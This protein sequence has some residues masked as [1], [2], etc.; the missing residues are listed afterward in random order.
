M[1]SLHIVT[2]ATQS[3]Y[4]YPYLVDTIKKNNGNIKVL[5]YGEKWQGFSWR[6]DLMIN[7]LSELDP[8]DIVCFVDG[9]DVICTRDLSELKVTFLDLKKKHDC[10]I[11]VSHH[12]MKQTF[13]NKLSNTLYFG[14]CNKELVNAGTYIG[15]AGDLLIMVKN[16]HDLSYSNSSDDQVLMTKY[17]KKNTKD[18]YIDTENEI[19]FVIDNPYKEITNEVIVENKVVKT[20]NQKKPFFIHG[21]GS[22][23]LDGILLKL[24]YSDVK[25]KQELFD[26]YYKKICMYVH[27]SVYNYYKNN[28]KN[29]ALLFLIVFLLFFLIIILLVFGF[30]YFSKYEKS[31]KKLKSKFVYNKK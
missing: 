31:L 5:G 18:F 16:I 21:P 10:K 30:Y 4:Y 6:Y 3:E 14:T 9:Y 19:F 20:Y 8:N 2:V 28:N 27:P 23:Y 29:I 24:G 7:Y 17:C 25:V 26:D 12:K 15:N 13:P 1:D 11:V 22:T